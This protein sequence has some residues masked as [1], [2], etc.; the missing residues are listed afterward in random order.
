M[1]PNEAPFKA[2]GVS[3]A[4]DKVAAAGGTAAAAAGPATPSS[5]NALPRLCGLGMSGGVPAGL[6]CPGNDATTAPWEGG[7][8]GVL[9]RAADWAA[10]WATVVAS[11]AVAV[12]AREAT[13]GRNG[14][15]ATEA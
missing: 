15:R 4:S 7:V 8:E 5:Q 2:T 11:S 9:G 3:G 6:A 13:D 10:N 14:L 1:C 12:A